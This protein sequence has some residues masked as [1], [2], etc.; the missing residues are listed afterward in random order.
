MKKLKLNLDEIKVKCLEVVAFYQEMLDS[1]IC[2][3]MQIKTNLL[4]PIHFAENR[5][6]FF[7]GPIKATCDTFSPLNCYWPQTKVITCKFWFVEPVAYY[8]YSGRMSGC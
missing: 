5:S 6:P 3:D 2:Q 8:S 4:Q 1:V 7:D